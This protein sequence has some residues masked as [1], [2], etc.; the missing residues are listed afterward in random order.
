MSLIEGS[1]HPIDSYYYL[2]MPMGL[3]EGPVKEVVKPGFK[4]VPVLG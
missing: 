1:S 3:T 2:G 4:L